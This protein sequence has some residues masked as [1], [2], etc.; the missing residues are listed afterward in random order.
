MGSG[1]WRHVNTAA[2]FAGSARITTANPLLGSASAPVEVW[3]Q[4]GSGTLFGVQNAAFGQT[5][6]AAVPLLY[7]GADGYLRGRLPGADPDVLQSN[8]SDARIGVARGQSALDAG[9]FR[10]RWDRPRLRNGTTCG[11]W[12]RTGTRGAVRATWRSG[13]A[14]DPSRSARPAPRSYARG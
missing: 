2:G 9:F 8:R 4:G 5:A 7:V 3:F 10:V 1:R 13:W 14:G 11:P 12:L 6:S